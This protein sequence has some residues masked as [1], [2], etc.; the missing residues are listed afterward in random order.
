MDKEDINQEYQ[1]A[2]WISERRGIYG[3][4]KYAVKDA[5]KKENSY[6]VTKFCEACGLFIGFRSMTCWKC[7]N[8]N[9]EIMKR[10]MSLGRCSYQ[11]EDRIL[12]K[13]ERENFIANLDGLS[14]FITQRLLVE[15]LI[16]CDDCT[17]LL[18]KDFHLSQ[19]TIE[20]YL[21]EIAK[22]LRFFELL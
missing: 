13:I 2:K 18:A 20:R 16:F 5:K 3:Y 1:L 4:A 19:R 7:G 22:K 12:R 10:Y 14:K 8:E 15:R 11:I 17:K 21:R 6:E 9:L